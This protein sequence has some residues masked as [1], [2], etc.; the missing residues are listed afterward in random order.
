[1]L[2]ENYALYH[3]MYKAKPLCAHNPLIAMMTTSSE[4]D[5]KNATMICHC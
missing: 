3:T 4:N 5:T 2:L 1:M